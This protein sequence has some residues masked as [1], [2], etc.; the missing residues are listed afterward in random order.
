MAQIPTQ[1]VAARLLGPE[2]APPPPI[3]NAAFIRMSEAYGELVR[4]LLSCADLDEERVRTNPLAENARRFLVACNDS[5]RV[6]PD[7][8]NVERAAMVARAPIVAHALLRFATEVHFLAPFIDSML[9]QSIIQK[10]GGQDLCVEVKTIHRLDTNVQKRVNE[11]DRQVKHVGIDSSGVCLI[12]YPVPLDPHQRESALANVINGIQAVT[13]AP[14]NR[15][16]SAVVLQW[17]ELMVEEHVGELWLFAARGSRLYGHAHAHRPLDG[18][19]QDLCPAA[20]A[21]ARVVL[22]PSR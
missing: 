7:F 5:A 22:R 21:V 2:E 17:D 1:P 15:S 8:A 13:R 9:Q 3:D 19:M 6:V 14:H 12:H 16:I 20:F 11:A 18:N 4:K 10:F